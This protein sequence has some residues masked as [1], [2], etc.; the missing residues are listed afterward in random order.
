[1]F[2]G[3][4]VHTIMFGFCFKA[5]ILEF[6]VCSFITSIGAVGWCGRVEMYPKYITVTVGKIVTLNCSTNS[7]NSSD[8]W[9]VE[10]EFVN[11][12]CDV[13]TTVCSGTD[14]LLLKTTGK[15]ACKS[16]ANIHT[17]SIRNLSLN[18][19]GTYIC[20]EDGGRGPGKGYCKL[21]FHRK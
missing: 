8:Q 13:S 20:V 9:G 15:Y 11:D 14:V 21:A 19:S 3:L 18:D 5:V 2:I 17:L 4:F 7:D 10:W 6:N 12:G 1:M 16:K